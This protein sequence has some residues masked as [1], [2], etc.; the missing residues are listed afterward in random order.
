[1]PTRQPQFNPVQVQGRSPEEIKAHEEKKRKEEA[2][3][4]KLPAKNEKRY[5]DIKL[6]CNAPCLITYRILADDEQ[7]ALL[8]MD[9]KTPTSIKPIILRK[10]NIKA[11]VYDAGSSLIR[12]VK[13]FRV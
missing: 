12:F 9:K 6:E 7:D 11:T 2:A 3:K 4:K 13:A 1:M 10:K 5:F 8:Q